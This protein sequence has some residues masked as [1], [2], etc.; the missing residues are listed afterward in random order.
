MN[1]VIPQQEALFEAIKASLPSHVSLVDSLSD[2]LG[3]SHDSAYRRM[4]CEK[5]LDIQEL[6]LI[7]DHYGV[8]LDSLLTKKAKLPSFQHQRPRTGD[9]TDWLKSM[10]RQLIQLQQVEDLEA[11]YVT[12]DVT[13][14]QLLQFPELAAFKFFL[15]MKSSLRVEEYQNKQF[16][17]K[18]LDENYSARTRMIARRY[19][20]LPSRE[21]I[22]VDAVSSFLK[23]IQYYQE[24][25][26]FRSDEDA[27]ALCEALLLMVAHLKLQAERGVKSDYNEPDSVAGGSYELY[28]NELFVVDGIAL[29]KGGPFRETLISTV[30]PSFLQ[31]S[32][33]KLFHYYENWVAGL[34][35]NAVPLSGQSEKARTQFFNKIQS[36]I[37]DFMVTLS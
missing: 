23:Q 35:R 6:A 11:T 33:S 29:I 14:F 10:E 8:S 28:M 2:L 7:T 18:E 5:A 13:T 36:Q 17:V 32:D 31:S 19:L 30:P 37:K 34:I 16:S 3:V 21:I 27:L 1:A 22:S 26:Y 24:L 4:R 25:H 9:L 12:H 15:W 20:S